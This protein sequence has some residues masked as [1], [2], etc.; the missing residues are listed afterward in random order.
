MTNPTNEL[1]LHEIRTILH[2][3][4]AQAR[5]NPATPLYNLGY[6]TEAVKSILAWHRKEVDQRVLEAQVYTIQAIQV[7]ESKKRDEYMK[8]FLAIAQNNPTDKQLEQR[9]E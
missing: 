2:A 9:E 7:L 4:G 5:L 8:V 6:E 3:Y 1:K